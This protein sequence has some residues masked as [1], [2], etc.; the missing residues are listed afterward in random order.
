MKK[1]YNSKG[2]NTLLEFFKSHPH[3][4]I[5]I[6]KIVDELKL[7]GVGESTVYRQVAGLCDEGILGRV[8][9]NDGKSVLYRFIDKSNGCDS[10]FHLKCTN[11]GNITHLH[12]D[13]TGSFKTHIEAHHGF[14]VDFGHTVIYGICK[15]CKLGV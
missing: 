2:R 8:N 1:Q 4:E 7:K 14:S 12:C 13:K 15:N 3:S 5:S 11:C 6:G 10:H 9:G